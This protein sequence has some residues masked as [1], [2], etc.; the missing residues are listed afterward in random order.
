MIGDLF[1]PVSC[2]RHDSY[3]LRRSNLHNRLADVLAQFD[4]DYLCFGDAAYPLLRYIT[5]G[6][7]RP[8]VPIP[9][10][11]GLAAANQRKKMSKVRICVEWGFGK[12]VN[13]W[14]FL[15][16][17]KNLQLYSQPVATYYSVMAMI[18]NC[19]TCLYGGQTSEFF[20]CKPVELE[21]YLA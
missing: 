12:I 6:T 16:F 4:I 19:H 1:G 20:D 5:R 8:R 21:E 13:L 11:V 10:A 17:K 7:R 3:L 15:D 18:T 9:G 2:R 14:A